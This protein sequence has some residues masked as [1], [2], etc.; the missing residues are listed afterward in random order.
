MPTT[1]AVDRRAELAA[2]AFELIAERGLDG[3][4]LRAVARRVG[5]TTGIVTHHFL[6]RAE[7]VEAA[8][9]HARSSMMERALSL[10][11]DADAYDLVAATL[12]LGDR[13]VA[14][15]R[16]WL[17]V[18]VAALADPEM[19]RFHREMYDQWR[20]EISRRLESDLGASTPSAVDHLM[21]V[22]DG[23]A[24]RAVLDPGEWPEDRQRSHLDT[25]WAAAVTEGGMSD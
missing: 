10:P 11:S 19:A 3:L 24:M 4:S 2:A 1:A 7:L 15:W 20:G 21:A 23:V 9:D 25:A 22:V 8:L 14:S 17:S 13:M 16:V 12:P 5:A 18:R 6:D